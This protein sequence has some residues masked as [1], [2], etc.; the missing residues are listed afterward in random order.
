M[1]FQVLKHFSCSLTSKVCLHNA[2]HQ[3]AMIGVFTLK[4]QV[5]SM[6]NLLGGVR[7]C[8]AGPCL[9]INKPGGLLTQAPPHI[10]SVE[11]RL[12]KFIRIRDE[13]ARSCLFSGPHRLDRPVSG[14][15]VLPCINVRPNGISTSLNSGSLE[16][17]IGLVW[18]AR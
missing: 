9:L 3:I 14:V 8:M 17:S 7:I 5:S 10:D 2:D 18:K 6:D 4:V 1:I 11:M 15:M 12:K 16:K 13:K